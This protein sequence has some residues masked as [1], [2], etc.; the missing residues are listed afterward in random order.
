MNDFQ[1][2]KQVL[3]KGAG[4]ALVPTYLCVDELATGKLVELL[5]AW[6][7]PEIEIHAVYPSRQ[8]VTPK[9]RA[10]LSQLEAHVSGATTKHA[11][12]KMHL[13]EGR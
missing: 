8:G 1:L 13:L 2:L 3:L 4:V 5:P 12:K 6:S 7:P 10:F 11:R 9:V